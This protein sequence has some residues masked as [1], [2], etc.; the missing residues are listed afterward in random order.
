[1][2]LTTSEF[3]QNDIDT[4]V[5]PYAWK[6]SNIPEN[7][8][9]VLDWDPILSLVSELDPQVLHINAACIAFL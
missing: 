6:P 3:V 2:S 5:E 1:M 8:D 7:L 4:C 9:V